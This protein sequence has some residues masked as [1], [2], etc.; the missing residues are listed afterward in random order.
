MPLDFNDAPDQKTFDL[1]ADN[2]IATLQLTVRPGNAGAGGWLRRSKDGGSE[3]LDCVI[4]VVGG[5]QDKK[6]F[7]ELM[8]VAGTTEGHGKAGDITSAK[9]RAI[10][11]SARG[12]KPDDKT[13]QARQA[14]GIESFGDLD[15]IRFVG[16]V[17]IEKG[18]DGYRDKNRLLEVITP[19]RQEWRHVE[20][21]AR[22]PGLIPS[23]GGG[24]G[25]A[26]PPGGVNRPSWAS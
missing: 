26:P 12:I 5:P 4:T 19:D 6:K 9:I 7:Y 25:S 13:P 11:E 15:G 24:G 8:T 3:A 1:V 17:T 21:V 14:R 18:K 22:S 23:Q 16:K 20:Q 10:L 2:T